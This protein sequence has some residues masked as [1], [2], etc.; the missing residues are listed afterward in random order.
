MAGSTLLVRQ[1][2]RT[3][4]VVGEDLGPTRS[5]SGHGFTRRLGAERRRESGSERGGIQP[6][7]PHERW[8]GTLP[9]RKMLLSGPRGRRTYGAT[10]GSS[11]PRSTGSQTRGCLRSDGAGA[12]FRARS[13]ATRLVAQSVSTVGVDG[14]PGHVHANLCWGGA[15]GALFPRTELTPH[16]HAWVSASP[17][18]S[19]AQR[20]DE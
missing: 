1:C 9:A 16:C 8:R 6:R 2:R 17:A 4:E 11:G 18:L 5:R 3:G 20:S 12:D 10:V 15:I 7:Q 13:P 14:D 19:H